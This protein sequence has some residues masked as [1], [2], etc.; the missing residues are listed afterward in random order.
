MENESTQNQF[1]KLTELLI[2]IEKNTSDK[3]EKKSAIEIFIMPL[4]ILFIG[5]FSTIYITKVERENTNNNISKD[6]DINIIHNKEQ[7]DIQS[8]DLF[9]KLILSN[10]NRDKELAIRL[11]NSIDPSMAINFALAI[12]L[13][14][15]E[16]R[17]ISF[18][19]YK[20][21][22]QYENEKFL[23]KV[24]FDM[25]IVLVDDIS[26]TP[27]Y[28]IQE[29]LKNY[30][31]GYPQLVDFIYRVMD[32]RIINGRSISLEMINGTLCDLM[33]GKQVIDLDNLNEDIVEKAIKLSFIERN[34]SL[35]DKIKTIKDCVY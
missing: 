21:G 4:I 31:T 19:A 1:I 30:D 18:L 8:L 16:D 2:K 9:Q 15:T 13:N 32:R 6:R 5:T 10:N 25:H 28:R 29:N 26:S 34:M 17:S 24:L 33:D 11:L 22:K 7:K 23:E 20:F 3:K 14:R 12:S 35:K 27:V